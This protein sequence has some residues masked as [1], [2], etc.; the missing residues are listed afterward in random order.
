M[1]FN[2][3]RNTSAAFKAINRK[4]STP[5]IKMTPLARLSLGVL[6]FYLLFLVG[7]LVYKFVMTLHK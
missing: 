2:F 7:I 3:F 1:I 5:R 6:R 4:Y